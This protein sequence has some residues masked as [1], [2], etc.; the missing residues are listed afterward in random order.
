MARRSA[1][2]STALANTRKGAPLGVAS[3]IQVLAASAPAASPAAPSESIRW[4]S[5][6]KNK[7][8][9]TNKA[10]SGNR[11]SRGHGWYVKYREG[12]GGRH[13]Q[14]EYWDR[15]NHHW[16]M[17]QWN[18]AVLSLGS[19][20]VYLD[21]AVEPP[22][23]S[24]P[25][26]TAEVA[27]DD[28][29]EKG[30]DVQ[31]AAASAAEVKPLSTERL[32]IQIASTVMP[33]TCINF[34]GLCQEAAYKG[35]ILYRIEKEVGVCG[36]DVLTNTGKTGQCLQEWPYESSKTA[37]TP[38]MNPLRR[39]LPPPED[40]PMALWHTAGT[41]T[42]LC[43]KVN[44]IDSRF[45]LCGKDAPHLDGIHRAFGKM[46]PESLKIVQQWQDSV[47]TS[48]GRPKSVTLR[49]VDCGVLENYQSVTTSGSR[50]EA[51]ETQQEVSNSV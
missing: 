39:D 8:R 12:R 45:I 2:T 11:G 43:P 16:D 50:K 4:M 40:E 25:T 10:I 1:A 13:L 48:Y 14:G 33:E 32:I 5:T 41:I 31:A 3:P 20:F 28:Q 22:A 21:I 17:Q 26:A 42:M 27:E 24:A 7:N 46:E 47:L 49:I 9:R 29:G 18:D 34:V 44:E 36:G 38:R 51:S 35:T 30:A 15:S 6:Q 23:A 19:Q 37:P